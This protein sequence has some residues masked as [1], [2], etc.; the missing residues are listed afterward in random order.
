V[1]STRLGALFASLLLLVASV[2]RGEI[3]SESF[4][5]E[6][7]EGC[8]E[9]PMENATLG[10][11]MEYCA[12][13]THKMSKGMTLEEAAMLGVDMLAAESEAD[14]QKMLLANEKAKNYIA[15]CVVRLYEE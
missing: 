3:T 1:V 10:A 7:F 4:L 15:Q 5:F 9:E 11:Q 6:V 13:F 8:I 12:C 2:A 14:G